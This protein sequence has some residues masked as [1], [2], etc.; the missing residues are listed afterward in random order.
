MENRSTTT[1]RGI[2]IP[3]AWDE[4]GMAKTLAIATYGEERYIVDESPL[5]GKLKAFLRQKVSA[6]GDVRKSGKDWRITITSFQSD[7]GERSAG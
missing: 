3:V 7:I 5:V 4:T 2:V 6:N 1:I